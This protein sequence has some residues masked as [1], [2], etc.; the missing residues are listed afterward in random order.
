M[1][2]TNLSMGRLWMLYDTNIDGNKGRERKER[3]GKERKGREVSWA[4]PYLKLGVCGRYPK[5]GLVEFLFC[6]TTS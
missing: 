3:K 2:D 1:P 5:Y 4:W 6:P